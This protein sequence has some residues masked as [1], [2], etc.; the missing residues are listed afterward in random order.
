MFA[1][2]A[3]VSVA[4]SMFAAAEPIYDDP[5]QPVERDP[6]KEVSPRRPGTSE[7]Q[8]YVPP[9]PDPSKVSPPTPFMR[10]E[11]LP[12]PDRWRIMQGLGQRYPW[13]DP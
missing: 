8:R 7:P 4:I 12:V 9:P 6:A 11:S 1:S 13:Y 3:I 2:S 10:R 5:T